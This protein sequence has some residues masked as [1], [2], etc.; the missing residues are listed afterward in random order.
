MYLSRYVSFRLHGESLTGVIEDNPDDDEKCEPAVSEAAKQ[1]HSGV[2]LKSSALS[3][4]A[5]KGKKLKLTNKFR[6]RKRKDGSFKI[7]PA[8]GSPAQPGTVGA[9]KAKCYDTEGEMNKLL[10]FRRSSD[11]KLL[12]IHIFEDMSNDDYLWI[13]ELQNSQKLFHLLIEHMPELACKAVDA[14]RR[15]L[16]RCSVVPNVREFEQSWDVDREIAGNRHNRMKILLKKMSEPS[17]QAEA[18]PNPLYALVKGVHSGVKGIKNNA[19]IASTIDGIA[20][21]I[22]GIVVDKKE[23]EQVN[24]VREP[25]G[26]CYEYRYSSEMPG[27]LSPTIDLIVRVSGDV[28]QESFHSDGIF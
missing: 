11:S 24:A 2:H 28:L 16:F 21:T 12:V 10:F 23:E 22:D 18:A 3:L 8:N 4:T 19:A 20:S 5:A 14:F 17:T 25:K 13:V 26:I 27:G 9:I 7:K 6:G 15:P 1:K